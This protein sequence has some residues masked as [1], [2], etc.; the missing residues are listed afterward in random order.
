MIKQLPYI[1]N[2]SQKKTFATW[3]LLQHLRENVVFLF[4]IFLVCQ[5][6]MG[7][8][9]KAAVESCVR[10]FHVYQDVWVPVIGETTLP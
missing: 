5:K 6:K 10:A 7:L 1:G 9:G 3:R 4:K 8:A 2:H